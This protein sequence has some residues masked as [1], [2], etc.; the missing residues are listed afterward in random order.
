MQ[1]LYLALTLLA[2]MLLLVTIYSLAFSNRFFKKKDLPP[3]AADNPHQTTISAEDIAAIQQTQ[4]Y[5]RIYTLM[6]RIYYLLTEYKLKYA[7]ALTCI[8]RR[9]LP[10]AFKSNAVDGYIDWTLLKKHIIDCEVQWYNLVHQS[11]AL[12]NNFK[13]RTAVKCSFQMLGF[14]APQAS[15]D[16]AELTF[17]I[18]AFD[19]VKAVYTNGNPIIMPRIIIRTTA[20]FGDSFEEYVPDYRWEMPGIATLICSERELLDEKLSDI[21]LTMGIKNYQE[22]EADLLLY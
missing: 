5:H 1:N 9:R 3:A 21:L 22:I 16:L 13:L 15:D 19:R 8:L 12:Q 2:F 4:C 10:P 17:D 20:Y 14:T 6:P 7:D 18:M 11:D